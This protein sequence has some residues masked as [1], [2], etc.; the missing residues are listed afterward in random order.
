[1]TKLRKT[2]NRSALSKFC[3]KLNDSRI[4]M[5]ISGLI[6]DI[7]EVTIDYNRRVSMHFCLGLCFIA[8]NLNHK[9][10][11]E[12]GDGPVG[13][14]GSGPQPPCSTLCRGEEAKV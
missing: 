14:V 1:M 2:A 13:S 5:Q 6:M 8:N 3:I 12:M 4:Q 11:M 10:Q 9:M 7:D